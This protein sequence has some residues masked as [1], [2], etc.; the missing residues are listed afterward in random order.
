V[1]LRRRSELETAVSY[2]PE[3]KWSRAELLQERGNSARLLALEET[4]LAEI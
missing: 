3:E 1:Q 2:T 4:I